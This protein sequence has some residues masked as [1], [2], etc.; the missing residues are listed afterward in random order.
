L[1]L[2]AAGCSAGARHSTPRVPVPAT[3]ALPED[4]GPPCPAATPVPPAWPARVPAGFPWPDGRVSKIVDN[5]PHAIDVRVEVPRSLRD[6][7]AFVAERLP[8][9]GYTLQ[10]GSTT[11]TKVDVPFVR[12]S[13]VYG[14][15]TVRAGATR[16]TTEWQLDVVTHA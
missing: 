11:A 13:T 2:L 4:S 6:S 16:C 5:D 3:V 7:A 8:A 14:R 10:G 15:L 12:G 1:L 9:A